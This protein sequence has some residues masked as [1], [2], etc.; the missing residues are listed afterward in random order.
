L[1]GLLVVERAKFIRE[2]AQWL[3]QGT[4]ALFIGA[5]LS[6][7]AGYPD[8]RSLLR[9]IA[10]ELEVDVDQEHDLAGVAQW[11]INKAGK[12]RTRIAQ[13][14]KNSFPDKDEVPHAF[15]IISRLPVRYVWTTNYDKLIERAW[16]LQRRKLDVKAIKSDLGVGNPWSDTTLYKMHG[17]VDHPADVVIATDDYELYRQTRS[18]FLQI[19]NGH[20]IG[21]HCLF[22]G[23]GFTDPN[24]AHLLGLIRESMGEH[25]SQHYAI[26][27]RPQ[28]DAGSDS[29]LVSYQKAR[30]AHW[31]SDMHR[32]GINCVEVDTFEE[33]DEIL[34]AIEAAVSRRSVFVSGS[35]PENLRDAA[36]D[37]IEEVATRVGHILGEKGL[38]L[39]S[40]F[41]LTVGSAVMAGVL[42][43]MYTD[44]VPAL[45][46]RLFLRPFP[47]K[48]PDG[49]EPG[50]FR[51]RYREDMIQ[52]AGICVFVGGMRDAGKGLELA[53]GVLEEFEIS[54]ASGRVLIPVAATGGA[55][56]QIWERI[57]TR[58]GG[59]VAKL[60]D[61]VFARLGERTLSVD[62]VVAA[63]LQAIDE[64]TQPT[65]KEPK[66]G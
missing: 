51:R 61:A 10:E 5:G 15:R 35:Y 3:E 12:Q 22:L 46:N 40:G 65:G 50:G 34:L 53:P 42:S 18:G 14:V 7:Q 17:T 6:M 57:K 44:D 58:G 41:G 21:L 55:S 47:Q 20:L 16:Y 24:V 59:G 60:S 27:C 62:E 28:A 56:E 25:A 48:I 33:I 45:D 52:Q 54:L 39:V 49:F 38:R 31:V 63:V 64:A 11:H 1:E 4:G 8:W 43:R 9:E 2:Y 13:V 26:V 19:L 23:F 36:R 29:K 32:Y 66:G 30:H 37:R